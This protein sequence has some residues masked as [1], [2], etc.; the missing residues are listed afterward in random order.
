MTLGSQKGLHSHPGN[1]QP[2]GWL[3]LAPIRATFG[4]SSAG[5]L[6]IRRITCVS[7][8]FGGWWTADPRLGGSTLLCK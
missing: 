5:R 2:T 8:I 7:D 3:F 6:V 1:V 4:S